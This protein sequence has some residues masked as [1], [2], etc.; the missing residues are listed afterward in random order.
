MLLTMPDTGQRFTCVLKTDIKILMRLRGRP[1]RLSDRTSS[2]TCM[3]VPSAGETI[4]PSVSG[5]IR[6]GLRKKKDDR[7]G[8]GKKPQGCPG[9]TEPPGCQ[10]QHSGRSNEGIAFPSDGFVVAGLGDH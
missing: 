10:G 8:E 6:S 3:T 9:I 1:G 2:K 4:M 5:G 7:D